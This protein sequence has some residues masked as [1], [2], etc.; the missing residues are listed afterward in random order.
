MFRYFKWEETN[1]TWDKLDMP[2]NLVD[3]FVEVIRKTGGSSAYVNGNPWDVTKRELGEEKTRKIIKLFCSV[4]NLNYQEILEK[5]DGIKITI[6]QVDR[7]INEAI[8]VGVKI[9]KKI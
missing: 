8:K 6:E 3:E 2:W 5:R 7:V 1:F 9:D 4:N